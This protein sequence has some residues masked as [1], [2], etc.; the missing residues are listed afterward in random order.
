MK[1]LLKI[2]RVNYLSVHMCQLSLSVLF[3]LVIVVCQ[4]HSMCIVYVSAIYICC[5]Y[6]FRNK[7]VI[8]QCKQSGKARQQKDL[9]ICLC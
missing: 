2:E 8:F 1:L 7:I 6:L 9:F 3:P 5:C 4:F